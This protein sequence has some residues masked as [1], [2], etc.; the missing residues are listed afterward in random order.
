MFNK[1]LFKVVAACSFWV[2]RV[3]AGNLLNFTDRKCVTFENKICSMS[4][5]PYNK[6][7]TN[8]ACSS[9]TGEYWHSV[10]FVRTSLRSVRAVT[11]SGQYSPVQSPRSVSKRLVFF[12]QA[13][14]RAGILNPQIWVTNHAL[15][16]GPAFYDTAHGSDFIP[17][18]LKF[19]LKSWQ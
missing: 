10:V 15:V 18:Y 3:S 11:T 19:A 9:R 12:S 5:V 1:F 7:F 8:L 2:A 13:S 16:A 17:L 4:C 6:L 14:E